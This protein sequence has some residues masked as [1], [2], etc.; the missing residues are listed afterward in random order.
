MRGRRVPA[1]TNFFHPPIS[2]SGAVGATVR[3]LVA[4]RESQGSTTASFHAT[5]ELECLRPLPYESS[6]LLGS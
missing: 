3:M 6:S 2:F 1:V 5:L 4:R